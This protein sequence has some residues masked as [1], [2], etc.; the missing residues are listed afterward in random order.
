MQ[1]FHLPS[2]SDWSFSGCLYRPNLP[3]IPLGSLVKCLDTCAGYPIAFTAYND[4]RIYCTCSVAQPD[5][6]D[7]QTVCGIGDWFTYS[8]SIDALPSAIISRKRQGGFKARRTR[9]SLCPEGYRA[10]KITLGRGME[11]ECIDVTQ[12]LESC[13]GCFFGQ[14][15]IDPNRIATTLEGNIGKDCS[16]MEGIRQDGVTCISGECI[17]FACEEGSHLSDSQCLSMTEDI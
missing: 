2:P 15:T 7:L 12:E 17:A 4:S 14:V 9:M 3:S 11:Y 8:E 5:P 10:C 1:V 16:K 6:D 13:G